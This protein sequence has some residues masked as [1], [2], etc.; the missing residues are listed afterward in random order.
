M[1]QANYHIHSDYCDGSNTLEEM[2][3]AGIAAGLSSLGLSSHFPLPFANDWTMK[4]D[5]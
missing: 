5:N 4:E 3:Q 2:V 1:L